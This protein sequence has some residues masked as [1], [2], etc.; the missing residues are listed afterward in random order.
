MRWYRQ[1][2][3]LIAVAELLGHASTKTTEIY[4]KHIKLDEL[5]AVLNEQTVGSTRMFVLGK[6]FAQVGS[7]AVLI[8]E[9]DTHRLFAEVYADPA[10]PE[11]RPQEAYDLIFDVAEVDAAPPAI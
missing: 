5:A 10:R 2:K 9:D 8:G 11:V 7:H 4:L 3:N 1:S 6:G